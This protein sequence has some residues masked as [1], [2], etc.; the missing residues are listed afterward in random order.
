MGNLIDTFNV[1]DCDPPLEYKF[2]QRDKADW[3]ILY[4]RVLVAAP[5]TVL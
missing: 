5:F 3:A 2:M 1:K 4:S